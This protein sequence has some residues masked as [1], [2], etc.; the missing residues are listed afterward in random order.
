MYRHVFVRLEGETLEKEYSTLNS[1]ELICR[2]LK[3]TMGGNGAHVAFTPSTDVA[4]RT[5]VLSPEMHNRA[6][7]RLNLPQA[8]SRRVPPLLRFPRRPLSSSLT[9][10]SGSEPHRSSM[11]LQ[12]SSTTGTSI[13]RDGLLLRFSEGH[14]EDQSGVQLSASRLSSSQ[15]EISK[16]FAVR[17]RTEFTR[18]V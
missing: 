6:T 11:F 15:C 5:G 8:K 4:E 9:R 17:H 10:T 3:E 7:H 12:Q 1:V 2:T 16:Q 14:S 13:C 18:K